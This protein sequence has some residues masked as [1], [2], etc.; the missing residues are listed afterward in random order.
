MKALGATLWRRWC[1]E[2][3]A[4]HVL[5][6]DEGIRLSCERAGLVLPGVGHF[7]PP[8]VQLIPWERPGVLPRIASALDWS[9]NQ[10]ERVVP[11][12]HRGVASVARERVFVAR[13]A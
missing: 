9:V 3:W 1:P 5:H 2:N 13:R 12:Y 11:L 6:T 4:K 7:G 8:L 10:V